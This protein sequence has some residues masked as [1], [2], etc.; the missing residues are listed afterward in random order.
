[1]IPFFPEFRKIDYFDSN[2]KVIDVALGA[3]STHVLAEVVK[4]N[5]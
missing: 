3:A 4:V 1:L 5:N 2:L